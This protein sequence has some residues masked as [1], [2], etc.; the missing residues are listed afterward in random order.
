MPHAYFA[1]SLPICQRP[2][3]EMMSRPNQQPG[4]PETPFDRL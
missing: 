4:T 3:T 1:K 2:R